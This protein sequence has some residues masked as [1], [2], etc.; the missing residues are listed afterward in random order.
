M[1][2]KT[3]LVVFALCALAFVLSVRT[4]AQANAGTTVR[5]DDART[6]TDAQKQSIKRI[7]T[8]AEKQAAPA[9]AR[10]AEI[11]NKI[12]ENMLADAPDEKL[13]ADLSAQ[14]E[15]ATWELLSIKGQSIYEIVRVLTPAQREL[16]KAEMRKP[17]APA[18]LSEVV[19]HLFRLDAK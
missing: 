3:L 6:L 19:A 7:Q 12:Y 15:K 17:G 13:R 4:S 11:V 8:N 14:M 2:L 5:E 10:L 1:R 16:V 9:A 18:D